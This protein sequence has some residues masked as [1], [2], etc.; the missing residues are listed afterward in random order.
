MAHRLEIRP[1]EGG[2]D[3]SHFAQDLMRSY[4]RLSARKG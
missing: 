1:A 2:A 3:A 4:I